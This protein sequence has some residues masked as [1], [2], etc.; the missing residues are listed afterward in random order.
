MWA[1]SGSRRSRREAQA[2]LDREL[3]LAYVLRW[4]LPAE[5]KFEV[6]HEVRLVFLAARGHPLAGGEVVSADEVG[7]AGLI[8]TPLTGIE[9]VFYREVLRD[10]G[11]AEDYSVLEMIE[12]LQSRLLAAAAGCGVIATF[13]P[14]HHSITVSDALVPL[15][16]E[17]VPA[18][19]TVDAGLVRRS[20]DPNAATSELA[21]WLRG[22]ASA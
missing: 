3:D 13:V 21:A 17:P 4:H 20:D 7:R 10:F 2:V 5:T 8:T 14:A 11:L 9:S 15:R 1:H 6:L 19:A 16:I 18:S 12:G 22:H